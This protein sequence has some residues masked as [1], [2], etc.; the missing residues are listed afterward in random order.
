MRATRAAYFEIFRRRLARLECAQ[1]PSFRFVGHSHSAC[2]GVCGAAGQSIKQPRVE[3]SVSRQVGD[4]SLVSSSQWAAFAAQLSL[5]RG[6]H[7]EQTSPVQLREMPR[8][9]HRLRFV[10]PCV[11]SGKIAASACGPA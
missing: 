1:L 6:E 9:R 7:A 4:P 2:D 10:R 8:G 11:T 3:S 5:R